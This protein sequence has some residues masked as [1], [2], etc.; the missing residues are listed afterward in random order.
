M[1]RIIK[2]VYETNFGTAYATHK[3]VF[4]KCNSIG[5]R[6][7]KKYLSKRCDTQVKSKP[8]NNNIALWHQVLSLN[9]K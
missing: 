8:K 6:Y 1:E 4:N 9:L 7:V 2:E 5:L 3:T